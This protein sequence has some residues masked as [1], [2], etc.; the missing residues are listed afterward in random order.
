M[1]VLTTLSA[2][3]IAV[4]LSV[5]SMAILSNLSAAQSPTA[6]NSVSVGKFTKLATGRVVNI[7]NADTACSIELKD[8]QGK[9]FY[10][11]GDFSL[12]EAPKKYLGKQV[13]LSYKLAK[14]M[15]AECGGNV[16]CKKSTTVALI[17]SLTPID[18]KSAPAANANPA[19]PAASAAA[20]SSSFCTSQEVVVF[21]CRAG[22][23]MVSV[24]GSTGATKSSGYLQYRF[25]KPS[26]PLELVLPESRVPANQAATGQNEPFAGGGGSW[27]RFSNGATSYVVYEGIGRWGPKGETREK[28]GVAVERGGKLVANVKCSA[29]PQGSMSPDWFEKMAVKVKGNEEFLFPD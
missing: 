19:V 23:K 20:A 18:G 22:S 13:R 5:G 17:T 8:E 29:R 25:G 9:T 16:D 21:S 27:L 3:R 4:I 12:C 10:E 2:P 14:V 6:A 15:A 11:D 1:H 26:D 24:C 28:A 7:T